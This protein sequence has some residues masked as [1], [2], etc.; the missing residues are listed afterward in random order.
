MKVTISSG[1]KEKPIGEVHLVLTAREA[2]ILK[3]VCG[4]IGRDEALAIL[5]GSSNTA[6][7]DVPELRIV[8]D[9]IW[10][11]LSKVDDKLAAE[12]NQEKLK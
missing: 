3:V 11:I 1:Q 2:C 5:A 7:T 9:T 6:D 10:E 8:T 4:G 12:Y